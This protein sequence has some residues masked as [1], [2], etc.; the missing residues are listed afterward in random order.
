MP[1]TPPALPAAVF[2][3][4]LGHQALAAELGLGSLEQFPGTSP[5][6]HLR[7]VGGGEEGGWVET[8]G[9]GEKGGVLEGHAKDWH[10]N[11]WM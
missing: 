1:G 3:V 7:T 4:K 2:L 5:Q 10:Y 8:K 11:T 9:W 6:E